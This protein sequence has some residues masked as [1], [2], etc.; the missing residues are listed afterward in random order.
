M[1]STEL[2]FWRESIRQWY[3]D[4]LNNCYFVPPLHFCHESLAVSTVCGQQ[5]VVHVPVSDDDPNHRVQNTH[6]ALPQVRVVFTSGDDTWRYK[7]WGCQ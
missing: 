6:T 2:T 1:A 3:P 7:H 4:V 5:A